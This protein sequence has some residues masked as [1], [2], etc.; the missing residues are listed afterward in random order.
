MLR[1]LFE[2]FLRGFDVKCPG[3]ETGLQ[4]TKE[5]LRKNQVQG[6]CNGT[7]EHDKEVRKFG[8]KE[9][10]GESRKRDRSLQ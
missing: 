3:A 8:E 6:V 10:P 5:I 2:I 7:I 1:K 9:K 4:K